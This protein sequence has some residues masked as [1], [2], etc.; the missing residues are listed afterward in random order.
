MA[1][2]RVFDGPG[3]TLSQY[4]D[5][6]TQLVDRLG[7]DPGHAANGVLFHWAAATDDGLRA[8]D[9]YESRDAADRLVSDGIGPVTA[10]MGLPAPTITE[11][12]VH[13]YLPNP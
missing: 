10:G 2:A 1:I 8:V 3:W 12:E 11:F 6:M 13:N 4:D 9:V 7:L 5:L